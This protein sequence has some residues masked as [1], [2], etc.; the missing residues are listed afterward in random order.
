MTKRKALEDYQ[1]RGRKTDYSIEVAEQICA[2][3][4]E[5]KALH[6][7]C[8]ADWAPSPQQVYV[9][10]MKHPEFTDL[11]ARAKEI[12]QERY[13]SEIIT[14]AD[15]VKDAGVARNMIDARKW[16]ASKV[17]PQKWGDRQRTEIT[18]AN[19]GPLQVQA[20]TIDAR[21]LDAEQRAALK[22]ILLAA[23][24]KI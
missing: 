10:L 22:E 2:E 3:I 4:I 14:I 20:Q 1:K 7:I 21:E 11:Y 18:G 8:E 12:Q 19:G 13:A 5:G 23:R 24:G 15:T 6:I 17:A 16:Y 9:W